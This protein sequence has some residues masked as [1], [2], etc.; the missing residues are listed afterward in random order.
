MIGIQ[1]IGGV[2]E[3]LGPK[4]GTSK[5]KE[6]EKTTSSSTDGV[7]IS[8]EAVSATQV[9]AAITNSAEVSDIRQERVEQA[10]E[11]IEQG[12]YKVQDVVRQVAARLTQY[13]S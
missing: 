3:P 10:R 7:T 4:Q 1:G 2:P 12:T 8:P 6:S 9:Q 13:I 11:S 5:A